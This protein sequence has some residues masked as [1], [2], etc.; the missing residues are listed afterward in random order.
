M[1]DF[2]SLNRRNIDY[3]LASLALTHVCRIEWV[4]D[5]LINAGNSNWTVI[6]KRRACARYHCINRHIYKLMYNKHLGVLIAVVSR[7]WGSWKVHLKKPC[8]MNDPYLA[9]KAYWPMRTPNTCADHPWLNSNKNHTCSW[10]SS[11]IF[12]TLMSHVGRYKVS[13]EVLL[14]PR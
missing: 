9:S 3:F 1:T 2:I 13:Q 12:L 6:H 7:R 8:G 4:P 11:G 5:R 14:L 10:L